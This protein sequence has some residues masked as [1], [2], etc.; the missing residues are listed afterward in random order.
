[1]FRELGYGMAFFACSVVGA[2]FGLVGSGSPVILLLGPW[3]VAA[4]GWRRSSQHSGL[5]RLQPEFR[6]V[7]GPLPVY[8]SGANRDSARRRL[9]RLAAG[10]S[11]AVGSGTHHGAADR[12]ERLCAGARP[13]PGFRVDRLAPASLTN[14]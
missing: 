3:L 1:M 10:A 7:P 12:A 5:Y 9:G 11:G 8:C 14:K 13:G 4:A 6:A 2:F